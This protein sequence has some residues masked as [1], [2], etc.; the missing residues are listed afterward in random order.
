M[1]NKRPR[2]QASIASLKAIL[3]DIPTQTIE[4]LLHRSNND[5]E[6]AV[7]MYFTE[8][9]SQPQQQ[10]SVTRTKSS[11]ADVSATLT[12]PKISTMSNSSLRYYI[13]DLVITG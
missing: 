8:P 6:L 3:G 12:Q 9:Q 10:P 4:N 1:S 5:V 13:G 7:N 11:G 2:D